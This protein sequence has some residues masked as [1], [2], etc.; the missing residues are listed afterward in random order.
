[1]VKLSSGDFRLFKFDPGYKSCWWSCIYGWNSIT[2]TSSHE[3]SHTTCG[4]ME[5]FTYYLGAELYT[6]D[7][8]D[9]KWHGKQILSGVSLKD[10]WW[11]DGVFVAEA[12]NGA[13]YAWAYDPFK[14]DFVAVSLY[15]TPNGVYE[16]TCCEGGFIGSYKL[17]DGNEHIY[18]YW[19]N[20]LP[21]GKGYWSGGYWTTAHGDYYY[22]DCRFV[23][24]PT[25]AADTTV[26]KAD[27]SIPHCVQFLSKTFVGAYSIK[28]NFGDGST[29]SE[30][31]PLHKYTA[32]G[33]Y[34]VTLTASGPKSFTRTKTVHIAGPLKAEFTADKRS[35]TKPL[36]VNFTDQSTGDVTSWSWNFGDGGTSTARNP[37]HTY[38]SAG[39]FNVSLT[40]TGPGGSNKKTIQNCIHVTAEQPALPD[41]I[42]VIRQKTGGEQR[43]LL[44]SPPT[45]T[46]AEIE[47][48]I[49]GDVTFGNANDNSRRIAVAGVDINGDGIDEI[50]V[51]E[52]N[53]AGKQLLKIFRAP[54]GPDMQTEPAIASDL[55]FGNTTGDSN[56]IA[57]AGLKR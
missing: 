53:L 22:V 34:T 55:T 33:T 10:Y 28:W 5:L 6:Y 11:G 23:P 14:H 4:E 25:P 8:A 39:D 57:L 45:T 21:D 31:H 18:R 15:V 44:F 52:Q 38:G 47:P 16:L 7:F 29:S 3:I 50:A 49:A 12:T 26:E 27:G 1:M 51:I 41:A 40:V 30:M 42:A 43:L 2:V 35:G 36:T 13:V 56:N 9:H 17:S 19:Y 37:S 54:T 24:V 20:A 32:A 48:A 46:G